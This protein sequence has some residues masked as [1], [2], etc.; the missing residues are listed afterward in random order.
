MEW[1]NL[2]GIGIKK[3]FYGHLVYFVDMYWV[4]FVDIGLFCGHLV[5]FVDIWLMFPRFRA[6][7]QEK[8]GNPDTGI[9][10]HNE[11]QEEFYI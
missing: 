2:E 11:M 6:L 4:Y 8:S 7:Y 9:Y 3:M 10:F 1:L 5:Y